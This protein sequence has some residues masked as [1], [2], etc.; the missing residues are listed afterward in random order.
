MTKM[1]TPPASPYPAAAPTTGDEPPQVRPD[2]RRDLLWTLVTFL[3]LGVAAGLVWQWVVTPASILRTQDGA[4]VDQAQLGVKVNADGLFSLIGL[5]AG[6]LAG[7][8]LVRSRRRDVLLVVLLGTVASLA[9]GYLALRLGMMLG[10]VSRSTI[11]ATPVGDRVAAP[12]TVISRIVLLSWP[13]GFLIAAVAV[14]WG[15]NR[16]Q[17]ERDDA[18][19]VDVAAPAQP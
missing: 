18:T 9:A 7:F 5:V 2:R 14:L 4:V 17:V 3:V 13:V 1:S 12:L 11:L 10:D 6:L 15:S 16:E 19:A 8:G